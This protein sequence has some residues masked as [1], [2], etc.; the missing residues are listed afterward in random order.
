MSSTT[1][2]HRF[3]FGPNDWVSGDGMV[4]KIWGPA[5]WHYLHTMSFNYPVE[6]TD[7][8]KKWYRTF[9]ESLTHVLP[10]KYC[11]QNLAKNYLKL[12]LTE[13]VFTSRHTFSL[14]VFELHELINTMLGKDSGLT[15][16]EVRERYEHFRSRCNKHKSKSRRKTKM[17]KTTRSRKHKGC[18]EPL[19]GK[20][21]KCVIQIVPQEDKTKTFRIKPQCL[22]K[23]GGGYIS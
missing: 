7:E 11:R 4:T 1:N 5:M 12:P 6:P 21:A 17:I 3:V 9:M 20:K 19:H 14:Y 13:D 22:K 2:N 8:D 23:R 18:T 10:C 16:E 15:F